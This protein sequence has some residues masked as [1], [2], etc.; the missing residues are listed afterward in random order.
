MQPAS[1]EKLIWVLVFGGMAV[2]TLG[3]FMLR[4][5]G[6]GGVM[7]WAFLAAAGVSIVTG[8]VLIFVRARMSTPMRAPRDDKP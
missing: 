8:V 4:G 1:V 7:A 5:G 3:L 2:F 6:G